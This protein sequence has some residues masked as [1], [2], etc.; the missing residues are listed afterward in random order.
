MD[1][2]GLRSLLDSPSPSPARTLPPSTIHHPPS[3]LLQYQPRPHYKTVRGN[4]LI[5]QI[6]SD[7]NSMS[8]GM[9][10]LD[11]DQ[12][13][14]GIK[15]SCRRGWTARNRHLWFVCDHSLAWSA[16]LHYRVPCHGEQRRT[17]SPL[18]SSSSPLSN[19]SHCVASTIMS[20]LLLNLPQHLLHCAGFVPVCGFHSFR[21]K[22]FHSS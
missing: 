11:L 2:A 16:A 15:R 6:L 20:L 22:G 19:V 21:L 12:V 5:S 9:G 14:S 17:G 1:S 10:I 18:D 7:I 13:S 4:D 8:S 3:S